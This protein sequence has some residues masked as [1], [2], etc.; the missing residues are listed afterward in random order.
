M[1]NETRTVLSAALSC[2]LLAGRPSASGSE[3]GAPSPAGG[4]GPPAVLAGTFCPG[5]VTG[6]G[7]IPVG[8]GLGSFHF[9]AGNKDGLLFA[10][11]EFI[12][13]NTGMLVKVLGITA[14][15]AGVS[16]AC[17]Q[18]QGEAAIDGVGG[19]TYTV[20]VCDNGEPGNGVDSFSI[21]L[22]TGYSAGG[23][24]SGGNIQLHTPCH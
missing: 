20:D 3:P 21:L 5:F 17:R 6:G 9:F 13:G 12:D 24:I 11:L 2:L 8:A 7:H 10:G 19:F 18:F 4:D 14:Y 16:E 22:S 23:T 15:D 1:R